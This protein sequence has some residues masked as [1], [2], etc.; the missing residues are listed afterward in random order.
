MSWDEIM[1]KECFGGSEEKRPKRTD[2]CE[3]AASEIQLLSFAKNEN[4]DIFN[5]L[6]E[7]NK[8]FVL[9]KCLDL[10]ES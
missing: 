9:N 7:V 4:K 3:E 1:I 5:L 10:I 6:N 2:D 8:C